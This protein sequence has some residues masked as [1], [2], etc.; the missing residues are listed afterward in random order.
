MVF[1]RSLSDSKSPQVSWTLLSIQANFNN[2]V[3]WMVST[4]PPI[5]KSSSPYTSFLVTL[6]SMPVTIGITVTF[7]FHCF[8]SSLARSRYLSLFLISFNFILQT[9]R[10]AESTICSF[11]YFFFFLLSLGQFILPGVGDPFVSQISKEFCASHFLGCA[12]II[13]SYD[14]I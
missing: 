6:P 13:C 8:F 5:S 3:V 1:L 2:A 14:Q 9:A 10:T 4:R 7:M 11:S 12:N